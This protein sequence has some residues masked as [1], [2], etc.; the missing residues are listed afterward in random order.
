MPA[1]A[2]GVCKGGVSRQHL[3]GWQ[4]FTV[5]RHGSSLPCLVCGYFNL[6]GHSV[7]GWRRSSIPVRLLLSDPFTTCS[8]SLEV[9]SLFFRHHLALLTLTRSTQPHS[10][11]WSR[12][13]RM[14]PF[15]QACDPHNPRGVTSKPAEAQ[16]LRSLLLRNALH[17]PGTPFGAVRL[18][19]RRFLNSEIGR[20]HV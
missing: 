14:D 3:Q 11:S 15:P 16:E 5:F 17:R 12:S 18:V 6:R 7:R 13:L 2:S 4:N 8:L 19:A 1:S 9:S 10:W 20:A